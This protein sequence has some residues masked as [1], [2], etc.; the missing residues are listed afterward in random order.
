[1]RLLSLLILLMMVSDERVPVDIS[2]NGNL[3]QN[4]WSAVDE[5]A[6][7]LVN[8]ITHLQ[9]QLSEINIRKYNAISV[10]NASVQDIQELKQIFLSLNTANEAL[11][12][13]LEEFSEP[14]A[15]DSL[16]IDVEDKRNRIIWY[17][18][19]IAQFELLIRLAE[20]SSENTY[21]MTLLNETLGE[22]GIET[23]YNVLIAMMAL[24]GRQFDLHA[25]YATIRKIRLTQEEDENIRRLREYSVDTYNHFASSVFPPLGSAL[26][27]IV[28]FT[29]SEAFRWLYP[30]Q[31]K[32]SVFASHLRITNRSGY[33]ITREQIR[34]LYPLLE[35]GD[36][37]LQRRE[38]FLS[39][40]GIPG[41]FT[42]SAIF[43]GTLMVMDEYFEQES[44]QMFGNRLTNYL[45][46]RHPEIFQLKSRP[47]KAG[48]YYSTIEAKAGGVLLE[49]LEV[50]ANADHMLVLRP[51]LSRKDK[52]LSILSAMDNYGIPYDFDFDFST[53]QALGCSELVYK[54]YLP[55]DKK[56]GL[57]FG[58]QKIAGRWMVTPND[59]ALNFISQLKDS[60]PAMDFVFFLYG[61][62]ETKSARFE[63]AGKLHSLLVD[64]K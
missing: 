59:I 44:Q 57:V 13:Y 37:L 21:F 60:T 45:D 19:L 15:P 3:R 28:D 7:I 11:V 8:R 35:P 61:D 56:N 52:L 20:Y 6:R 43:T 64:N 40:I 42:H 30:I 26:S 39:N 12:A 36:I 54:S 53:S 34:Q 47:D 16:S 63:S 9:S 38:G 18:A 23:D 5:S 49:P 62:P 48:L 51:R 29:V 24:P 55:S 25:G 22:Y 10:A 2:V 58:M 32:V 1:M 27:G 4:E 33:Y 14:Q 46:A 17:A 41:F 31:E 50:S